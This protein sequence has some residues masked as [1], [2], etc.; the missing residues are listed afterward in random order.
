MNIL[1]ISVRWASLPGAGPGGIALMRRAPPA[2]R[3]AKQ[4]EGN[5]AVCSSLCNTQCIRET[6]IRNI[7]ENNPTGFSL[8]PKKEW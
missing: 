5:N 2:P 3:L 4:T 8:F 7:W 6:E 1:L